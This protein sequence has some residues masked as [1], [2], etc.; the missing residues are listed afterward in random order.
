MRRKQNISRRKDEQGIIITL[1]AVFMLGVIG[2]MAA[3]SID[4]VTIYTA[5]S[6]AQIAA[7]SAA[8]AGARVL[9]NSGMTSDIGAGMT[10]SAET[11]ASTV[12]TQV[13][14]S[15]LVGGKTLNAG[16][17]TC[18]ADI[19]VTFSNDATPP[20][21]PHIKVTVQ[22]T[23]LPTFFAR[24]WGTTK[25]T[26]A[27]SATAEAY[28][29]SNTQGTA[30][31]SNPPVAPVCVKPWILPNM[32]PSGG[33]T[34]FTET[35]PGNNSGAITNQAL[36]GWTST[37]SNTTKLSTV[38][39]AGV[40]NTTKP[41]AWKFYPGDQTSFPAPAT[42]PN[43]ATPLGTAYEQSS[44]GCVQTAIACNDNANVNVDFNAYGTRNRETAEAVNCLT[45]TRT[46]EGDTLTVTGGTP[47][48]SAFEF[49]AGADNPVAG[50]SPNDV[51]L[52]DSI[53]TVPVYDSGTG[54]NPPTNPVQIVGFVQLFLNPDGRATPLGGPNRYQIPTTVV[55]LIGCGTG[56]STTTPILG[57]GNSPVA[58]RLISGP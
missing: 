45:H 20:T 8:L 56:G 36:L 49:V 16:K 5:R 40:C 18:T 12:A 11:L 58:V 41:A 3:L 54:N 38:C 22:R 15:N 6:E 34:I 42:F 24:I 30:T 17:S 31:N 39:P 44:G 47:P 51:M 32:D 55:N 2:A 33:T 25:L 46:N 9:A 1:V 26:V 53:V 37:A 35:S 27:A 19:C 50:V 7:D 10:T 52:S 21:N 43:C 14:A 29:P 48:T 57:N 23:D 4:V 28:N 13:A